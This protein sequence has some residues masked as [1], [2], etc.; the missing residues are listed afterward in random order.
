MDCPKCKK[1]TEH[2]HKHQ[3]AHGIPETHLDGTER[4]E[5]K[6]CGYSMYKAEGEDQGLIFLLD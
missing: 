2:S 3:C 5:C 4:F 6:D 1:V